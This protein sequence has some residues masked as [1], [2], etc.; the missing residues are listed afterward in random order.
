MA[1][2]LR[3]FLL[4]ALVVAVLGSLAAFGVFAAFSQT[5]VNSGNSFAAGTVTI[6]DNDAGSALY[7]VSNRKPGDSVTSCIRVT[8]SGTLASDV[9]L[10]TADAIGA[11]GPYVDLTIDAGTQPAAVFPDCTGFTA[12]AGGPI[13]NG[14]LSGFATAHNSWATGLADYPGT[15]A[16]SWVTSDVV[17]YRFT[18]TLQDNNSAAGT[19][20][21][22]HAFTWE[23]RNQ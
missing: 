6:G 8:Y 4:S 2:N 12:D 23:A 19:A 13:F 7:S 10:Y 18:V 1:D 21:G 9:R 5:T 20:S 17:V 15:V 14:T 16:T 11:I 3:K 22:S